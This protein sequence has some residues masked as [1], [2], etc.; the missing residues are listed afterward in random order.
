MVGLLVAGALI[1]AAVPP[2]QA[3]AYT[4]AEWAITLWS[5]R[6][7]VDPNYMVGVAACESNLDPAA[8]NPAS[9]TFGLFQFVPGTFYWLRDSGLN[10]D[11]TYVPGDF[12]ETRDI[13]SVGAQAH[14]AAWA[15]AHGYGYLWACS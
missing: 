14:V 15:F 12:Y 3:R 11:P 4:Y 6:Y 2:G 13:T 9:G 10:Q 1:V 8:Y 5:G 7:G